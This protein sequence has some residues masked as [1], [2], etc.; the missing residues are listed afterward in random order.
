ME[1][2]IEERLDEIELKQA[3]YHGRL[4][5]QAELIR[6]LKANAKWEKTPKCGDCTHHNTDLCYD[7]LCTL[8]NMHALFSPREE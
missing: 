5:A 1:K 7:D 8:E 6:Q 4:C 2:T 3:E